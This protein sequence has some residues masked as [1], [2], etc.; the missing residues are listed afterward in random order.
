MPSGEAVAVS[1]SD[2]ARA[3]GL[4]RLPG[5]YSL[6][7]RLRDAGL[8]PELIAECL[9]VEPEALGPLL[10]IAEAKLA[11]IVEGDEPA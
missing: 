10:A 1:A 9:A 11:A 6:A 2:D 8:D 4:R 3:E 7:L 5:V